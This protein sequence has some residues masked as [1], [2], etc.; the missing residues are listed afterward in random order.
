MFDTNVFAPREK[1]SLVRLLS[2][3]LNK[4]SSRAYKTNALNIKN[5]TFY[6]F[7]ILIGIKCVVN[8]KFFLSFF[9]I[10]KFNPS[11]HLL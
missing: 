9:S 2:R 10:S 3:P 5:Y 11:V 6:K 4:L 1:N 8:H 7:D